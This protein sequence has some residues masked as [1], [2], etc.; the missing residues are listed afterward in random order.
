MLLAVV[1]ELVVREERR[2]GEKEIYINLR[3]AKS[4]IVADQGVTQLFLCT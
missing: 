4:T 1:E 3:Q 2:M